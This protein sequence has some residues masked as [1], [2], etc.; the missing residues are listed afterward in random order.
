[1]RRHPAAQSI[2]IGVNPSEGFSQLL[3]RFILFID[4][5]VVA[6]FREILSHSEFGVVAVAVPVVTDHVRLCCQSADEKLRGAASLGLSR[7]PMAAA[8]QTGHAAVQPQKC[9]FGDQHRAAGPLLH[10]GH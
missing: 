2:D 5:P 3:V 4:Q 7:Q 1:M 9:P 6:G 8:E 10:P